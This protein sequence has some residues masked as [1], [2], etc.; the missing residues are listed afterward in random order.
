MVCRDYIGIIFPCSLLRARKV[1]P[2]KSSTACESTE[3]LTDLSQR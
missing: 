2:V 1:I 3:S